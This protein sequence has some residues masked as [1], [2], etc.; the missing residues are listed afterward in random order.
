M[1]VSAPG[2][3]KPLAVWTAARTVHGSS[4]RPLAGLASTV[5][6]VLVTFDRLRA[7]GWRRERQGEGARREDE[8]PQ[9][10]CAPRQSHRLFFFVLGLA[11]LAVPAGS[12][13]PAALVA[14][15]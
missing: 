2:D 4:Q 11:T 1:I 8:A 10:E 12:S 15:T 13:R 6:A 9:P 14:T 5:S 7:A 3:P